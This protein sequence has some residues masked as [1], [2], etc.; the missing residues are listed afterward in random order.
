MSESLL[1]AV[2]QC[3]YFV[4]L[5]VLADAPAHGINANMTTSLH[6]DGIQ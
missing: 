1:Q 3:A 5:W 2:L 6:I 4:L